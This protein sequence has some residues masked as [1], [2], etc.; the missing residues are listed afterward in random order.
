MDATP[1]AAELKELIGRLHIA[2]TTALSPSAQ[3]L[4]ASASSPAEGAGYRLAEALGYLACLG[5]RKDAALGFLV[6]SAEM[7][8][9]AFHARSVAAATADALQRGLLQA[10]SRLDEKL[11]EAA[12]LPDIGVALHQVEDACS[13]ID[14]QRNA[15][16]SEL[17]HLETLAR[18]W[19]GVM[20][21]ADAPTREL[22]L[23]SYRVVARRDMPAHQWSVIERRLQA[24]LLPDAPRPRRKVVAVRDLLTRAVV[25]GANDD[26][27]TNESASRGS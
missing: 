13:G 14:L 7:A 8:G 24:A 9:K 17:R 1:V 25:W 19:R 4:A 2:S 22:I 11:R 26:P 21:G 5:E 20:I 23:D 16:H 3:S 15:I 27:P 6:R 18:S 10:S 12:R